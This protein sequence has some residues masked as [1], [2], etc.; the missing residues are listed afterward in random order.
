MKG[1]TATGALLAALLAGCIV[2]EAAPLARYEFEEP[3]MGT[4]VRI[5][6]YA[7]SAA[8]AGAAATAA[9]DVMRAVNSRMSDYLP[10]SELSRLSA[11]AGQGP[12]SVSPELFEVLDA[13]Q[14]TSRASAGAFDVTVGPLVRLWRQS[15]KARQLPAPEALSAAR[16]LTGHDRVILSKPDSVLLVTPGMQLDLGG[17]AKGH[18]C[19]RALAAMAALGVPCALVDTGGGL[20]LGDPPP[21]QAGWKIGL[22]GDRTRILVL[23]RCG[24][25][26]SGDSEQFVE[27]DG[28]RYSHILNP[29]TGLGLTRQEM[30][31]VVA[32]DGMTADALAT[33]CCVLGGPRALELAASRPGC[34]VWLQW[35]EDRRRKRVESPGFARL[36]AP[37]TED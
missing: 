2:A 15:R 4:R 21:G 11:A 30:A 7:D 14:R 9:F 17:I 5:V 33:A 6:L 8:R 24:V 10:D 23:S 18:A 22:L 29:A 35:V 20:A 28:V 12:K 32:P 26:T 27:I 13:A 36:T 1:T 37:A 25:A 3:H 31:T 16:S 34:E 19:D